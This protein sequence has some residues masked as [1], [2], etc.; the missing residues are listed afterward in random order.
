[1]TYLVSWILYLL[2]I[3]LYGIFNNVFRAGRVAFVDLL[4]HTDKRRKNIC[5]ERAGPK[6]MIIA[7][8]RNM[9]GNG[10]EVYVEEVTITVILDLY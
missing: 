2:S 3:K 6:R 4:H 5:V 10:G 8:E 1:M 7:R 9:K